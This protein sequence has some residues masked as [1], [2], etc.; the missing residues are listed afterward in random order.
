MAARTSKGGWPDNPVIY[1]IYPRSFC[2][3][4]GSGEGDLAG[5]VQKL[6]HIVRLDVDGIWMS[7]FFTSPLCDGGYDVADHTS[8]DPR[9]GTLDDF[10]EVVTRAHDLGLRVIID[11]VFNHTSD[12]HPWFAKSLAKEEPFRDFYVWADPKPNGS[13]PSNW[14]AYF[15]KPAW[16]WRPQRKQYC[17]HQFLDCQ[18]CLDHRNP[19]VGKRLSEIMR[20]WRDRG[21]DGFR[22]DAVTSFFYDP[23]FPD[24]PPADADKRARI[25][26]PPS[27]PFTFQD[28]QFDMLPDDCAGFAEKLRNWAGGDAYLLGEIN[29]GPSS[30]ETACHFTQDGRLDAAYVVDLP[31]RGLTGTVLAELLDRIEAPG[32]L[33]WWLSSHDQARHVSRAGDGSPHD[34]KMCAALLLALPGPV[35]IYQ[36]EELGMVQAD[37]QKSELHDPFDKMYWPDPPGRDGA[38]TPM[39]WDD[40]LNHG[41]SQGRPWL[42][43]ICPPDG[44][45]AAQWDQSGSVL[46]FYTRALRR[47]RDRAL[48]DADIEVLS[49]DETFFAARL[50]APYGRC[51]TLI[52]NFDNTART[53]HKSKAHRVLESAAQP[54]S[55]KIA[56]RSV[57][58]QAD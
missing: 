16:Q 45:A 46:Q 44:P 52:A 28:H 10:D 40:T 41:F 11:Q 48:A 43:I 37:L 27:N 7:P 58:W 31:E 1:Q 47:R 38:R 34:A 12:Q 6:D 19:E 5:V 42:P 23:T 3:S 32:A 49:A 35:L 9:F 21:V 29:E 54:D 57:I 24:N 4:T 50:Q 55:D 33:A 25:P 8:V 17:L 56:P 39:V 15:G 18:P 22:F 14:I 26:G 53:L 30:V 36:G 51:T 13:P 20:F 2:D